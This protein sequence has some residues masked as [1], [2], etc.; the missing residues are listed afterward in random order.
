MSW[1]RKRDK[2]HAFSHAPNNEYI[3]YFLNP[4]QTSKPQ[5]TAQTLRK[6]QKTPSKPKQRN[7]VIQKS[8]AKKEK[9][10]TS[11]RNKQ[12]KGRK[13]AKVTKKNFI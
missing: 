4:E 2:I 7:K 12:E 3:Q 9:K 10:Q 1:Y 6:K 5:L 11:V 13:P 8:N